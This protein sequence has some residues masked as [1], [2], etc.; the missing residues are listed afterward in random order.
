MVQRSED[1]RFALEPD[2]AFSIASERFRQYLHCHVPSETR[3]CG[4][5]HLSHAACAQRRFNLVRAKL[6]ARGEWHECAPL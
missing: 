5:V 6:C 1:F 3:I 4:T 2:H